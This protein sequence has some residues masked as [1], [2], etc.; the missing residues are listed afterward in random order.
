MFRFHIPF[1][2]KKPCISKVLRHHYQI[3]FSMG[4]QEFRNSLS[5]FQKQR[6]EENKLPS[7]VPGLT[8]V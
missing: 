2:H 3:H 5:L 7:V 8:D 4:A 6:S 1:P